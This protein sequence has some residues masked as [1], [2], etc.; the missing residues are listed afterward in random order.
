MNSFVA[1]TSPNSSSVVSCSTK[2]F[3]SVVVG[4]EYLYRTSCFIFH[5]HLFIVVRKVNFDSHNSL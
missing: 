5:T 2:L 3:E 4:F 1:P